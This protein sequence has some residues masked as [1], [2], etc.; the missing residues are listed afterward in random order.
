MAN[1][2]EGHLL[3]SNA[4]RILNTSSISNPTTSLEGVESTELEQQA[5]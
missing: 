1:D 5:T 3:M 4:A 2:S